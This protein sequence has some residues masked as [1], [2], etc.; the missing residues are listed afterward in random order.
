[1]SSQSNDLT[2]TDSTDALRDSARTFVSRQSNLARIRAQRSQ[3]PG[4]D[5]TIW[6]HM[7]KLGWLGVLIP[8]ELGGLGV[9]LAAAAAVAEELSMGLF[10]EPYSAVAVLA[11]S[12]I[13]QGDN[14]VLQQKLLPDLMSGNIVPAL[15]WQERGEVLNPLAVATT[16][17][18]G[19]DLVT[20]SGTKCFVMGGADADGYVVSAKSADDLELYWVPKDARGVRIDVNTLLDGTFGATLHLN[21]VEIPAVN[22]L[23][24][25]A[26]AAAALSRA[27]DQATVSASAE[28]LGTARAAFRITLDYLR[29]RKQF[30]QTIGSFQ[31]LQHRAV[32]CYV[33]IELATAVL[34]EA[35]AA[36]AAAASREEKAGLASRAKVRCGEAAS[37]IA[38]EAIQM[39]GAMGFTD[40]C[41]V[42]LYVKR[43]LV[44][45][46][47]LGG[48]HYHRRRFSRLVPVE[49]TERPERSRIP[50][51]QH[52]RD[53]PP[54]ADWNA[55]SDEDFRNLIRDFIE[56]QY[57]EELRYL[58]RRV[59]WN[60]VR[61]FNRKLA[62]RGGWIAPG[63]PRAWGGMGLSPAK[64]FIFMDETERWGVG[65]APDQGIRQ[66]GPVLFKYGTEEQKREYLPKILSCEHIWCQGY[67][68]PNAGSD[69]AS[70]A[71]FAEETRDGFIINGQKIWTSLANDSTHIY[72]LCRT[73]GSA[74]KQ[75]GISFI[76]VDLKT[77]GI[78]IRPI[79]DIAGNEEFCA[80]FFNNVHAPRRN[81]V[82]NLNEG[83]TVAKAVLEFERLGVGS[84][85]R[86]MTAINR[87]AMFASKVGL[88]EDQG[89]VD[90]FTRLRMNF[91]DHFTLHVRYTDRVINGLGLGPEV[92]ALKIWGMDVLQRISEFTLDR[93]EAYG[94]TAGPVAVAGAQASLAA[95]YY[96]SRLT[97]IGGGSSE[98]QRN[99]LAK[100]VLRLGS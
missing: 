66:L 85:H 94:T 80:V 74:K 93:A 59:R 27:I 77:P 56:T 92:S 19:G 79:R 71:T 44:L 55:L 1:M 35:V 33:Q 62:A 43:S 52:L 16:A 72:V 12:V 9:G 91:L 34:A 31:A 78:T 95:I 98:I 81:L 15:G 45:S 42:S 23:A 17:T 41:D 65:R 30:G 6:R 3:A 69:L 82:G 53:L 18:K 20:I 28:L 99:I 51:S 25:A 76:L 50:L 87:V 58:P 83:W 70:V 11:G 39:H 96:G 21:R 68:E 49:I 73:D 97:T 64:Q 37:L 26:I 14:R 54:D 88:F 36:D 47:W 89:F 86:P 48:M 61:E 7:A 38:R 22:Q 4:Y 32:D 46:A 57:P 67:S 84:P 100:N 5:R 63:W 75:R 10:P 29:T 13:A 40:D 60:E 8:E 2:P 90:E 24:S